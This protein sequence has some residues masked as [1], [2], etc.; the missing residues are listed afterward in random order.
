MPK[1]FVFLFVLIVAT[2][3]M[4]YYLLPVKYVYEGKEYLET[5]SGKVCIYDIASNRFEGCWDIV[6]APYKGKSR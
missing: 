6:N 5:R 1:G 4:V 3:A 2:I